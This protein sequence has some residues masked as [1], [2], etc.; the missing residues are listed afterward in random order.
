MNS[1]F[2]SSSAQ[3]QLVINASFDNKDD[4]KYTIMDYHVCLHK[5]SKVASSSSKVLD[6]VCIEPN[7]AFRCIIRRR[8]DGKFYI[9]RLI[10]HDCSIIKVNIS[11]VAGTLLLCN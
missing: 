11:Y 2:S 10:E 6:H 8:K 3:Q 1:S 7:C 4:A 9:T 5:S